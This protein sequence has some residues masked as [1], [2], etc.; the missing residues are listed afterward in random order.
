MPAHDLAPIPDPTAPASDALS[1][2]ALPPQASSIMPPGDSPRTPEPSAVATAV[3]LAGRR[4][5]APLGPAHLSPRKD[6]H[7]RP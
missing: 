5:G 7:P 2:T 6:L 1:H 3:Q 4:P